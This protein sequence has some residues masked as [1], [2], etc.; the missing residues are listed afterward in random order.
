MF[1]HNVLAHLSSIPPQTLAHAQP[2]AHSSLIQPQMLIPASS[3]QSV[4]V[5]VALLPMCA[6]IVVKDIILLVALTTVCSV[7]LLTVLD[8]L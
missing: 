8:V 7:I 3:V 2:T 6:Q 4:I 1:A 5:K